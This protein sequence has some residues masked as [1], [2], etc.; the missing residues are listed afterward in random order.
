MSDVLEEDIN[1]FYKKFF[2]PKADFI[3]RLDSESFADRDLIEENQ[4][5]DIEK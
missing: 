1:A 4:R 2:N 3:I 5:K